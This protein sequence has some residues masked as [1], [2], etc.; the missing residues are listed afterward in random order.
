MLEFVDRKDWDDPAHEW[1][2]LFSELLGT[3]LLLLVV[4]GGGSLV[5]QGQIALAA[6]RRITRFG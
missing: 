3:F 4:A 5:G 2:R 1:R 6:A